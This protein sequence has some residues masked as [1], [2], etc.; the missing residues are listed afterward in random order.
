MLVLPTEIKSIWAASWQNQQ[1]GMCIQLRQISLG[2][3]PVWSSVFAVRMKK[4]WVLSYPLSAQRRLLIWLGRCSGWYESSLG[5]HTILLVLSW[6]GS[7]LLEQSYSY[8]FSYIVARV[9]RCRTLPI[10]FAR[11]S[12]RPAL[13]IFVS[14]YP[15]LSKRGALV[16]Q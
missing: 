12:A 10:F 11:H 13:K 8:P 15:T 5:A 2:I 4:D 14:P 7:F 16:G 3:R 6:G 9:V 1:H